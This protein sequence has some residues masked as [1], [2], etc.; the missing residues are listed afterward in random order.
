[1]YFCNLFF[2]TYNKYFD[3][4]TFKKMEKSKKTHN[5]NPCSQELTNYVQ[6][7]THLAI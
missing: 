2:L 6:N 3:N 4:T 7:G 5:V 1:M